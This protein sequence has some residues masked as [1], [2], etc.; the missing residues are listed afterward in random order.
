MIDLRRLHVLRAVD[1][2]GS[3]T[4]A[5]H[6]LHFTPSAASQQIRQLGREL[7][8]TLLEPA[9]RKV[10][11]TPSALSLLAHADAIHE[12]WERAEIELHSEWQE[13]AGLL[14]LSAF[15][16][17]LSSLLAPACAR[18][19]ER[20]PRLQVRLREDPVHETFN[21]LFEGVVE[22]GVVEMT[23][24]N[25][26]LGDPRFD[27]RPL[28]DDPFDLV[29]RADHAVAGRDR[30]DLIELADEDWIVPPE[31]V[32]CRAQTLAACTA[33]GFT[34]TIA[35]EAV[36][37]FATGALVANGLGVA[38]VP[39]MVHIPPHLPVVRVPCA[40]NPS[41]KLLTATRRGARG[42]PGVAAAVE[43]LEE[44]APT[45]VAEP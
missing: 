45:A 39:R 3:V 16:T 5:A 25:P 43:M 42:H 17:A 37:W 8:V 44:L 14:R 34:P 1:H 22:L 20:H 35:H 10:R 27:Q 40:G 18:L 21:L 32:P 41:R 7:G 19:R 13:A 6:A 15:P 28:L 30:I 31:V 36:E 23:P 33:A 38:L 9:G 12:R 29:V 26:T 11:L 2:Y 24:D 4:A